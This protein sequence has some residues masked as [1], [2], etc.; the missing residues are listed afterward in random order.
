M[1]SFFSVLAVWIDFILSYIYCSFTFN[2]GVSIWLEPSA[3]L[4]KSNSVTKIPSFSN[5]KAPAPWWLAV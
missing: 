2:F 4:C 1:L 5:G 3:S